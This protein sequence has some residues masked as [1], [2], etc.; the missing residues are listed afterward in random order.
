MNEKIEKILFFGITIL[1][2]IIFL[3]MENRYI[4]SVKS[5]LI[6]LEI[7]Y[8]DSLYLEISSIRYDDHIKIRIVNGSLLWC[9]DYNSFP[10]NASIEDRFI[11]N[12][13]NFK[14]ISKKAN[15]DTLLTIDRNRQVRYYNIRS[16][17]CFDALKD[18][19]K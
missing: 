18:V 4:S 7:T 12:Y 15:N 6:P 11:E 5:K 14:I 13:L 10:S 8:E 1:C 19:N 3:Y 17:P 9:G 2:I 16:G